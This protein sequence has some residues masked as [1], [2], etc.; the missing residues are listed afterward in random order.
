MSSTR[1][2]GFGSPDGPKQAT[3]EM[4]MA[5]SAEDRK[6]RVETIYVEEARRV[7]SMFPAGALVPH[8]R[9]DFLLSADEGTIG[10]EVT[11]LCREAPRAE[12]AKLSKVAA[13]KQ[14]Y[15]RLA[16]AVPVEVSASFAPRIED[17]SFN[18][19]VNGLADFVHAHRAGMGC[20]NWNDCELPEGYCYVAIHNARGGSGQWRT[21]KAFDT[22]LAPKELIEARI[23]EKLLRLPEYRK[24]AP[25]NW[26]LIV[27][28]RFLG[29]GEVYARADHI[30]QWKFAFDFEKVL[31]FLREPGGSGEVI[32]VQRD[33]V[34]C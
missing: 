25:E 31:L 19:L 32:E 1:T 13:A 18:R 4:F 24:A 9:P 20:F 10:I 14:R 7:S 27:N 28:D 6:K 26:L 29:A 16:N 21:F 8:E 15:D 33:G 11:E 22:T 5:G 23:A 2:R 17:I 30:A 12:G 34:P 3:M